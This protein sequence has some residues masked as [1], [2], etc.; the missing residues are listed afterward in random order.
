MDQN[1]SSLKVTGPNFGMALLHVHMESC[2]V[3][4][5]S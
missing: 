5:Y 3:F 4:P 2:S 1:L